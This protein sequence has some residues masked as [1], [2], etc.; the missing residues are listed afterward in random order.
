M[1]GG[2]QSSPAATSTVVAEH[3]RMLLPRYQVL[4]EGWEALGRES[5]QEEPAWASS[6]GSRWC[7]R[8]GN[9]DTSL[10]GLGARAMA[11]L[12]TSTHWLCWDREVA[13]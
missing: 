9:E 7:S 11:W 2:D 1:Q 4:E 6:S 3:R 10:R 5:S 12:S 13:G 8:Q